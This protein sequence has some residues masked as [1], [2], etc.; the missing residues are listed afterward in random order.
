LA[1]KGESGLAFFE[2]AA[3]ALSVGLGCRW[4]AV[5]RRG[6]D[7][8]SVE[9][10]SLAADG[11]LQETFSYPLPGSPCLEVY[12][13]ASAEEPQCLV[14]DEIV[15]QFPEDQMLAD[16]G[17]RSYRG[18]VFFNAQGTAIGHVFVMDDRPMA[19]SPEE[20]AFFRLVTQRVGAEFNR[21]R[22]EEAFKES[23]TRLRHAAELA[24]LGHWVWDEIEDRAAFCSDELARIFGHES[25]AEYRDTLSSLAADLAGV[26]TGSATTPRSSRRS[27]KKPPTRSSTVSS[28]GRATFAACG[29][30]RNRCWMR[31]GDTCAPTAWSRMSPRR[32]RPRTP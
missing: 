16:M 18:E 25:G 23:E 21:W 11:E 14:V 31:L 30:S 9:L 13:G 26:S 28:L 4:A 24:N 29:K 2:T 8:K 20:R 1:G 6:Q 17:A 10:L 32:G 22:A 7:E 27:S 19:D 12:Q 15:S 5:V 3:L